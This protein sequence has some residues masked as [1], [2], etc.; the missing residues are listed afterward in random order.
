MGSLSQISGM[1][2]DSATTVH[3]RSP[4]PLYMD[5]MQTTPIL[6]LDTLPTELLIHILQ[7]LEV[8]YI[9]Q[10]L[11]RVCTY[12]N[13]IAKDEATWKIRIA[14]QWPGQY[15][16]IPPGLNF[17]WTMACIAREEESR[18]WTNILTSTASI[19]CPTAHYSSVD[20]VKVLDRL[21]VSGSR[22]RGINIWNI[23]QVLEGN[24]KPALKVPDAHK[25]WVWSFTSPAHQSGSDQDLVSGSW[26]NTVK[27]WR[28]TSSELK[29]TRKPVNVKV[30][31]LATDMHEN[32]VVAGTYDKKVIQMDARED[33]KKMTFFKCHTKPV[34][35][36]K[37]TDRQVISLSEDQY[38]VVYDRAAGK[39]FKRVLIPGHSF[40]MSMSWHGNSLYVG[41]KSG[42]LYLI[43][44]TNDAFDIVQQYQTGHV[45][46][47]TSVTHGL[48]SLMTSSSDGDIRVFHP[49][50]NLDLMATIKNPDCGE[51]AQLSY[52]SKILAGAFSNNTV[53]IW[54]RI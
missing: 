3:K 4:S 32:R 8:R 2:L 49:S 9:T 19:T 20:C 34:L 27:F 29:E 28:V 48:G 30:A 5:T 21:V 37:I 51:V 22:D 17:D 18:Q 53:K 31:V 39:R 42:T 38:L 47:I 1:D 40:P 46:K 6:K 50:R 24:P 12:F 13:T 41:D 15:P 54:T 16:A 44:T 33:I 26:D 14:K 52:N 25:G 10:V 36:V 11:S 7:F 43:D 35:A 23:D 45:G